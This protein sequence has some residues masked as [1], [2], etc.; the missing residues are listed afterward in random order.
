VKGIIKETKGEG[1]TDAAHPT[2]RRKHLF[3]KLIGK[4]KYEAIRTTRQSSEWGKDDRQKERIL[5]PLAKEVKGIRT[6]SPEA[7]KS[8]E[9]GITGTGVR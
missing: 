1:K 9:M 8:R 6:T 2:R 5:S 3:L 4:G 7:K